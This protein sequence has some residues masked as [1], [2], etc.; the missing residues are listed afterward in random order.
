MVD[1]AMVGSR[2]SRARGCERSNVRELNV[3]NSGGG[4][5]ASDG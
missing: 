5:R 2:G 3:V 4:W 1:L